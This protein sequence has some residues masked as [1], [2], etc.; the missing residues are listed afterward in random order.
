VD[1]AILARDLSLTLLLVFLASQ[2][3][4]RR[5][6]VVGLLA[7]AQGVVVAIDIAMQATEQ[8]TL[9]FVLT[10]P[11]IGLAGLTAALICGVL[12]WKRNWFYRCFCP[13]TAAGAIVYA[14]LGRWEFSGTALG[15]PGLLLY[16]LTGIMTAAALPIAPGEQARGTNSRR[17]PVCWPSGASWPE[18]AMKS[19]GGS[20]S[21]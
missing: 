7:G 17:R 15:I 8:L 19:C 4:G 10:V 6:K 3:T 12:E 16:P 2:L 21:R 5:R 11:A 9:Y 18:A 14:A 13:L 20:T 1:V